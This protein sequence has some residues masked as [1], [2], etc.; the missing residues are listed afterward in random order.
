VKDA[1]PPA[2]PWAAVVTTAER[3]NRSTEDIPGRKTC[4]EKKPP[5][6][7]DIL[8]R[9]KFLDEKTLRIRSTQGSIHSVSVAADSC[10]YE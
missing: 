2:F 8:G 7:E 1:K 5:L 9:R 6:K 4:S 10:G 3:K